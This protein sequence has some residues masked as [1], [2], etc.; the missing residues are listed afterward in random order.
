LKTA[1]VGILPIEIGCGETWKMPAEL[2]SYFATTAAWLRKSA[3]PCPPN[4]PRGR[5]GEG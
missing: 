1:N 2:S 4:E 5:P 3:S